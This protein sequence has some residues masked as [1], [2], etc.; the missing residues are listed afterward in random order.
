MKTASGQNRRVASRRTSVP[1]A[2]TEKSVKGSLAAQS[3]LRPFESEANF[4]LCEIRGLV[5]KDVRDRLLERGILVRYF[6]A[7]GIKNCLRISVG[8]SED[9]DRLMSALGEIG[10]RVAG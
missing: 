2:F 7:P 1:L 3:W 10:A 5:A 4:L 8:K 9:T 6:D